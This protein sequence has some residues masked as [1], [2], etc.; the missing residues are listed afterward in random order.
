MTD[1]ILLAET[2][3][4][5]L[6][7][8]YGTIVIDEAHER[9][10]NIDFLLGFLRHLIAKTE[11]PESRH[12]LRHHR[13]GEVLGPLRRRARDRGVG[14]VVPGRGSLPPGR[15]RR[16][17]HHARRR[18]GGARGRGAGGLPRGPGRRAGVPAGRER[19]SRSRG[20]AAPGKAG[21]GDPAALLATVECR[22]GPGV[23]PGR[24]AA[25]GAG[26]ER[27]RDLA[28]GAAHPLRR[29]HRPGARQAL[30]L[31]EQGGNAAGREDRAGGR[32]ATRRAL[33][34][35]RRRR[36]LPAVFARTSSRRGRPSPTR[37]CCAP[38]SPR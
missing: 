22:A 26:D 27:G 35:R 17:G 34:P 11:R 29:G 5:P 32:A 7:R 3:G 16:G 4:D 8:A 31:P 25:R 14:P 18:G 10:L 13:R 21:R 23:P 24:R 37:S 30:Q 1:G 9:S 36:V 12:Y 28:H 15:R 20:G 6:L 33:R 38:R 2:Q 19:D